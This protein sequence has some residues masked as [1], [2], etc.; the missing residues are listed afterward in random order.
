MNLNLARSNV[1]HICLRYVD[2]SQIYLCF[3]LR[4]AVW[5]YMYRSFWNK[6][7]ELPPNYRLTLKGQRY[8][9]YMYVLL[10]SLIPEFYSDQLLQVIL[11]KV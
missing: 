8:P 6:C 5:S 9:R 1:P 10:A 2:E 4:P 11:R 7:A 3:S